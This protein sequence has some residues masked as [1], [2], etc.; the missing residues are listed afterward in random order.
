MSNSTN[1]QFSHFTEYQQRAIFSKSPEILVSASAGSGKTTVMVERILYEIERGEV[2]IA[3]LL[4]L[5][6]SRNS[7]S[8]MKT[9]LL[10]RL[11]KR[12]SEVVGSTRERILDQIDKISISK[13]STI[14][15]FCASVIKENF[16]YSRISPTFNIADDNAMRMYS[17]KAMDKVFEFYSNDNIFFNILEAVSNTRDNVNLSDIIKK[18]HGFL[19]VLPDKTE[20][21]RNSTKCFA[22]IEDNVLIDT[23]LSQLRQKAKKYHSI[24]VSLQREYGTNA[25][26]E[27]RLYYLSRVMD[28]RD[29]ATLYDVVLEDISFSNN[30]K[31]YYEG[32]DEDTFKAIKGLLEDISKFRKKIEQDVIDPA[33][34]TDVISSCGVY[35]GKLLGAVLKYDEYL[36]EIKSADNRYDFADVMHE[37][38]RMLLIDEV[39]SRV[40]SQYDY[41]Y[42]DEYQ[43]TNPLQE[44]ILSIVSDD[45][46]FMVG[47]VKQSIYGFR[48]TDPNIFLTKKNSQSVEN[49]PFNA[50]FRTKGTII[51]S[52][53]SLFCAIM[54][55]DNSGVDYAVDPMV[56]G[57][58]FDEESHQ[59]ITYKFFNLDKS[60][61]DKPSGV[62][63]VT[64]SPIRRVG[65]DE[66]IDYVLREI[67]SLVLGDASPDR[68]G[69]R[70]KYSDIAV[71][72]RS[73]N[74]LDE[75]STY[76]AKLN[77]PFDKETQVKGEDSHSISILIAMLSIIDNFKQD[78]PL[79]T[80]MK[81]PLYSFSDEDMA[82]IRLENGGRTC[83]YDAVLKSSH[84]KVQ[85]LLADI[86]RYRTL[87]GVLD[88]YS[89]ATTIV[90]DKSYMARITARLG[91]AEAKLC[92][93]FLMNLPSCSASSELST[94]L[95]TYHNY[96]IEV[97]KTT[98]VKDNAI[99][100]ST[101]HGSKGLEY[102]IVFLIGCGNGFNYKDTIQE[103]LFDKDIGV[104]VKSYDIDN[105]IKTTSPLYVAMQE[106]LKRKTRREEM[107]LLYVAMTRAQCKLYVTGSLSKDLDV[108]ED[109]DD[110]DSYA[111]WIIKALD[112][113]PTIGGVSDDIEEHEDKRLD[114]CDESIKSA[115][116]DNFAYVYPHEKA[117]V[118]P[119]KHTATGLS[120]AAG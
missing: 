90:E 56:A 77:I 4:V 61:V 60:V 65:K 49:I 69:K 53:N 32:A 50:N 109:I 87:A 27:D 116:L 63:S 7:A 71:L 107:R 18:I 76:L 67:S 112:L 115:I 114:I 39:A 38:Y 68:A 19:Q 13:I 22:V 34:L 94:F 86:D 105:R 42:I 106:E 17:A 78:I 101:I 44:A 23:Y 110:A 31:K 3:R 6:F 74:A 80:V 117:T 55:V 120:A 58:K 16:E 46:R 48:H 98:S 64:T 102:P 91:E 30:N 93:T 9:K 12:A 73:R 75:L 43:D 83:F 40:K 66:E 92:D 70:V 10:N 103:V 84:P 89:L 20:W 111:E 24:L 95:Y 113:T 41:T 100:L 99:T 25:C 79:V 5:T 15:G 26:F 59:D 47:D 54:R 14:D 96:G 21:V 72:A 51:D 88:V 36:S 52:I 2:D 104:V 119:L 11:R 1:T 108:F 62:Y 33:Q 29:Y 8:D 57:K 45:K 28:V 35:A 85:E 118:T 81:S 37:C 82:S 97:P